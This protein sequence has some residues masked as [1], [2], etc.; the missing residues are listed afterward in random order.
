VTLSS[1]AAERLSKPTAASLSK[2]RTP[3]S[4]PASPARTKTTAAAA[5]PKAKATPAPAKTENEEDKTSLPASDPHAQNGYSAS[6]ELSGGEIADEI[7]DEHELHEPERAVI[8]AEPEPGQEETDRASSPS[9]PSHDLPATE[10]HESEH[11]PDVL[12]EASSDLHHDTDADTQPDLEHHESPNGGKAHVYIG[13]E[14]EDIVNMLE[15]TP[16]AKDRPPSVASIPDEEVHEI[17]DEE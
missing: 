11:E 15:G 9:F 7:H 14:I 10:D 13:N 8:Y 2:A 6:A 4:L 3:A 1:A 17:P 5:K 12:E 16:A